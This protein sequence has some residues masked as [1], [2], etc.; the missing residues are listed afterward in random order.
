MAAIPAAYGMYADYVALRQVVQT[1][2]QS[3]FDKEDICVMVSPQHPLA[4]V[5]REANILGAGREASAATRGTFSWLMK[6]GALV[7]PSVGLFIR[8]RAFL[9]ALLTCEDSGTLYDHS[10][11][12]AGLGFSEDEAERC[13]SH[14][15]EMGVLVYVFCPE[16]EKITSATDVMRRMGAYEAATV[17]VAQAAAA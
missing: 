9:D 11:A 1:L 6:L 3:G 8:S 10:H 2:N 14:M 13:E 7:I 12:L 5:V 15:R 16:V 4:T 17:E